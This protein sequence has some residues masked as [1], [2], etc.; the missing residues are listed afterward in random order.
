[1]KPREEESAKDT[2]QRQ[3]SAI[4]MDVQ[5]K[6]RREESVPDTAL[7]PKSV[8]TKDA[9]MKSRGKMECVKCMEPSLR[10]AISMDARKK[11]TK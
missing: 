7:I 3:E 2:E 8:H 9:P 10:Y 1:M 11:Y 5:H 4:K 6:P